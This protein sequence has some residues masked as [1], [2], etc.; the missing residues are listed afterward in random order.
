MSKCIWNPE[1]RWLSFSSFTIHK[2]IKIFFILAKG[3]KPPAD[4][5]V[6]TCLQPHSM[7]SSKPINIHLLSKT[8]DKSFNYKEITMNS[9]NPLH[10]SLSQSHLSSR[11]EFTATRESFSC[12][13]DYSRSNENITSKIL[14]IQ[15]LVPVIIYRQ[16][17]ISTFWWIGC[18]FILFKCHINRWVFSSPQPK[19]RAM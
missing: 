7:H 14:I 17:E 4:L 1:Q 13:I 16:Y 12:A 8:G 5:I 19:S 18:D 3:L 15:E 6:I 10:K 9:Q 2:S 11:N